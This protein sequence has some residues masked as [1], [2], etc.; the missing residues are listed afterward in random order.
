MMFRTERLARVAHA[1]DDEMFYQ[2]YGFMPAA[3]QPDPA[4]AI[5]AIAKVAILATEGDLET[6]DRLRAMR[7]QYLA[8]LLEPTAAED[9]RNDAVGSVSKRR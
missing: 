1:I 7:E 5:V 2:R 8:T 9:V 4:P 3:D 6:L